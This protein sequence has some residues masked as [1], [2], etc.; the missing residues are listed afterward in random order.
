MN[1]LPT[2]LQRIINSYGCMRQVELHRELLKGILRVGE[3]VCRSCYTTEGAVVADVEYHGWLSWR[4]YGCI[5]HLNCRRWSKYGYPIYEVGSSRRLPSIKYELWTTGSHTHKSRIIKCIACERNPIDFDI[6]P[7]CVWR[8]G[9]SD[10][11]L[12]LH[13]LRIRE[14]ARSCNTSG[15]NTRRIRKEIRRMIRNDTCRY[16]NEDFARAQEIQENDKRVEA[17]CAARS[18]LGYERAKARHR[19]VSERAKKDQ[20]KQCFIC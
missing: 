16:F 4:C 18:R 2:E 10:D 12:D 8:N 5:R 6:Y 19:A 9:R 7:A 15:D 14:Q 13:I 1:K 11:E 3:R 17:E 20:K